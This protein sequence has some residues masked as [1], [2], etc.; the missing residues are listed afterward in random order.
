MTALLD[1]DYLNTACFLSLNTDD[2]KYNMVLIMAQQ[3]L[4]QI[5][6]REFYEQIESQYPSYT[7]D[8]S[9]LYTNYIKD[10]LAWQTYFYYLKFANAEATPTGIREFN[11]ENS[12]VLSD[13]KM[14][15]FEKNVYEASVRYKN[16]MINY[17]KEQQIRDSTKF[18]L[19]ES[20]C[21]DQFSFAISAID[22][23][24]DSLVKVNKS[25]ITNE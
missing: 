8:N 15:S 1:L 11:D 7:G 24:S 21:Q 13:V 6:G 19:Y 4:E 10:Y 12:S 9:T 3:E 20:K 25:I 17:I 22:K 2:K 14:Y 18:P 23:R 16:R 5:L